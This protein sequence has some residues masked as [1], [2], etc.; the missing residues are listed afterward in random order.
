M[1]LL[2]VEE[3]EPTNLVAAVQIICSIWPNKS[4][5]MRSELVIAP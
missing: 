2:K 4:R 5:R 1:V 3:P